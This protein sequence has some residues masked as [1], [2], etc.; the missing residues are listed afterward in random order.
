[1]KGICVMSKWI[2]V[3]IL[4]IGL[5]YLLNNL[6]VIN[7]GIGE[8]VSTYWPVIIV[9]FGVKLLFRG[10][11]HFIQYAK[12]DKW[13]FGS[14]LWGSAVTALGIILLGNRAEWF[15]VTFADVWSWTWPLLIIFIGLQILLNR[16]RGVVVTIEDHEDR[17]SLK[18]SIDDIDFESIA[19][20]KRRAQETKKRVRQSFDQ[21]SYTKK[22]SSKTK[23]LIGDVELGKRPW[24]LD[25][26]EIR[27]TVGSVEVDLTTAVLK[28]GENY[29]DIYTWV[30]S[31]EITAPKD[32]AIQ[33][34]VDVNIGEATLFDDSYAGTSRSATYTSS[35]FEE[36]EKK[37]ILNVHT[38][39]GSVEVMAV[40]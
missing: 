28:E 2:G 8:T 16:D 1:M 31:V 33:A 9:L 19:K 39:M 22:S 17:R 11:I 6:G 3:I 24:Q 10:F 25:D 26:N 20:A 30:G 29:L 13:R 15:A 23:Q 38:N 5:L 12:R 21:S 18:Q 4:S 34:T 7:T 37:L 35:N 36:A 27:L 14:L 32:L 40:D